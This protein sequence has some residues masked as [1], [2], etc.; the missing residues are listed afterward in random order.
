MKIRTPRVSS[1]LVTPAIGL[2]FV[3]VVVVSA[4]IAHAGSPPDVSGKKY[5]EASSTLSNA[6][7]KPVVE[8]TVGDRH[9]WPDCVVTFVRAH[10][11]RPPPNSTGSV[12]HQALVS[13]NCDAGAA[14]SVAPGFSAQ[15]PE[16]RAAAAAAASH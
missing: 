1:G 10:D 12:T 3:G 8:T 16:G 15:S 6:G 9:P 13:L 5:G 7:Y 2:A 4:P 11:R 14:S